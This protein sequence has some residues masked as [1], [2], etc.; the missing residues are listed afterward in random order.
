MINHDRYDGA[1]L[2]LNYLSVF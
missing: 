2:K 1:Y